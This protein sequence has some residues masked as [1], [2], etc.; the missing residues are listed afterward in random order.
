MVNSNS[1]V[2]LQLVFAAE[3]RAAV[4]DKALTSK[5]KGV[6]KRFL[7]MLFFISIHCSISAQPLPDSVLVLYNAAKTSG[8]KGKVLLVYFRKSINDVNSL[9]NLS[10]FLK[11]FEGQKDKTGENYT[12]LYICRKLSTTGEYVTA[13][14][15]SLSL[16]SYFQ[17]INDSYGEANANLYIG[18]ALQVSGNRDEAIQFLR[19]VIPIA[20]ALMDKELLAYTYNGIAFCFL[21]LNIPDSAIVFSKQAI[22]YAIQ[23]NDEVNLLYPTGTLGECYLSVRDFEKALPLVQQSFYLAKKY[24]DKHA[25]SWSHLDFSEF[26]LGTNQRDSA[27][28]YARKTIEAAKP[29]GYE[30]IMIS[31][32]KVL[33]QSFEAE[34]NQDSSYEYYRLYSETKESLFNAKKAKEIHLINLDEL[35]R[36]KELEKEKIQT[37]SK[38][39]TYTFL[40]VLG[41][42]LLIALFLYRNNRQKQKANLV[43][44]EQKQ[45]LESTLQ[46][47]KQTQSQLIQSEKMASLGELTAGIAHEIQNPL[48]FV[49]NFSEVNAELIGELKSEKSKGKNERDEKLEEDLLNDISQNLEKINHHGKR[50]DAIVKG[51][52]QHSQ[53][54]TGIKE[55]IDI[56]KLVDEYLRLSYHGLRAKDKTFNATLTT[57]FDE[58][59]GK[60]NI[61]PQD[62]G[63]VILNLI[64]N[65]FYAVDEKKKQSATLY[66]PTV[67]V[68]TKKINGKVEIKVRDNGS[69]IPPK[70]LDKIF[71]P[72]FTTKPTGQGT[73][74]GLSLS[75]DIIKGHGG[76]LKVN[77]NENK[78]AEFIVQLP[79]ISH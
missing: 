54:S 32:Y 55:P 39:R 38:I 66:E 35:R 53:S 30:D 22:Q 10:S 58:S 5:L 69:G 28:Y 61:I 11:Y 59:I 71:Q 49:N 27:R 4:P 31:A 21:S 73:G 42:F 64:S 33:Y 9:S 79:I 7:I 17:E 78:Y 2:Y 76:D 60:V 3:Y 56:N 62:I 16:L 45:K 68:S 50:A 40:T 43:L 67:S 20:R 34:N 23:S 51:M 77:T 70:V 46:E 72:F 14:R 6:M 75:Y 41:S 25:I 24:N 57:D 29:L 74:L 36:L 1:Q 47:L 8:E 37:Q 15:K 13:L 19:K 63:R 12:Q 44:Q 26:Y 65:A 48:N 52:L 18:S